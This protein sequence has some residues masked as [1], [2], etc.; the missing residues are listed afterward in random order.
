MP[1]WQVL[2]CSQ[3]VGYA[4]ANA[5]YMTSPYSRCAVFLLENRSN[6]MFF[7]EP[8][9]VAGYNLASKNRTKS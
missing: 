9:G 6:P 1:F 5:Q 2:V 8:E 3:G 4:P 7:V